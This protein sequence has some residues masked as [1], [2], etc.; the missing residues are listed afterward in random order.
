VVVVAVA[1]VKLEAL[2]QLRPTAAAAKA[3]MEYSM[4]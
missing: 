3:V 4:P 2:E 1:Q